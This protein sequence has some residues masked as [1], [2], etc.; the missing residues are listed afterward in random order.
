M[1]SDHI[2]CSWTEAPRVKP[3]A[4]KDRP[5]FEAAMRNPRYPLASAYCPAWTFENSMGPINLWL[6]EA[7]ACGMELKPGQ[8]ILDLGCGAA[9]TSIF[10]AREFGVEVWA[11]DLWIDPEG[12]RQRI[13]EAGM[14]DRAYPLRAEAHS[15]PFVRSS[16][17]A[18]VS[19]DAYHYFG[20]EM[21]FLSYLAH[22]VRP[23]GEIGVVVPGNA[24]DPD[25][26]DAVPLEPD[27][28]SEL[29]A[30][31]F[32]FRSASWWRRH[33]SRCQK[34]SVETAEMI[35]GGRDDWLRFIEATTAHYGLAP[36]DQLD[37]RMLESQA[38][39]SLGFCRLIARRND[40]RTMSFGPGDYRIA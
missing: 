29:D 12:N 25:D 37:S 10:L 38:G 3:S 32:T 23:G 2:S 39:Q 11:A 17:D 5:S 18:I 1:H 31:W 40:A 26:P 9:S 27:L 30:D 21:R 4:M 14:R 13:E 6:A 16:F 22:F 33:W 28:A 8:R 19:V 7:L 20:T 35:E 24:V 36:G 15:L 34:V